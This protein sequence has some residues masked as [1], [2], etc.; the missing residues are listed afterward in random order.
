MTIPPIVVDLALIGATG[1]ALFRMFVCAAAFALISQTTD[2][3]MAIQQ[4]VSAE[5]R[6]AA[7]NN[8]MLQMLGWTA[9]IIA[10][11]LIARHA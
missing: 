1:L 3:G 6:K 10:L 7:G 4:R 8:A 5:K 9:A 11:V 2:W